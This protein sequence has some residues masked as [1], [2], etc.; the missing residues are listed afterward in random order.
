MTR[1][2]FAR[3]V[4]IAKVRLAR[5]TMIASVTSATAELDCK[6]GKARAENMTPEGHAEIA[7]KAAEMRWGR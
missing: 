5:S 2:A 3:A 7:R 1:D 6:G 4:L